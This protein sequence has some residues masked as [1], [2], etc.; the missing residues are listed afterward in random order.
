MQLGSTIRRSS[1]PGDGAHA[2]DR[3]RLHLYLQITGYR[4]TGKTRLLEVLELIASLGSLT[5]F[6]GRSF[7]RRCWHP[8]SPTNRRSL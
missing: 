6:S 8:T 7:E 5:D 4:R 3:R 2:C 1:S